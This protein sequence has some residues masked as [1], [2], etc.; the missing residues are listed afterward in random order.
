[1]IIRC[2]LVLSKVKKSKVKKR[3]NK[4]KLYIKEKKEENKRKKRKVRLNW[5]GKVRCKT[6]KAFTSKRQGVFVQTS[7]R[8]K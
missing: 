1:M 2:D 6:I 4:R 3:R 5:V 8:F 7:R